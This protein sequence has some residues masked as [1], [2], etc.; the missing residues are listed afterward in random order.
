MAK[1]TSQ[2]QRQKR[3]A[4]NSS[5]Y[6]QGLALV[7]R[8]LACIMWGLVGLVLLGAGLSWTEGGEVKVA[9][10]LGG[11]GVIAAIGGVFWYFNLRAAAGRAPAMTDVG[12]VMCAIFGI[13]MISGGLSI[14]FGTPGAGLNIDRNGVV[15]V[16]FGVVAMGLGAAIR[17]LHRVPPGKKRIAVEHCRYAG[18][19]HITVADG[20]SRAEQDRLRQSW[21]ESRYAERPDWVSGRIET[22]R[23]RI[24]KAAYWI[25]GVLWAMAA[26]FWLGN[27]AG[28]TSSFVAAIFTLMAGAAS[29]PGVG[30]YLH[31]RKFAP[32]FLMPDPLPI[33][34]G[35]PVDLTVETGLRRSDM[36]EALCIL[37]LSCIY[38]YT[39]TVSRP[40]RSGEGRRTETTQKTLWSQEDIVAA[41][42]RDGS[43][44]LYLKARFNVPRSQ[45]PSSLRRSGDDIRWQLDVATD[46]PGS[47]Y[48]V[49]FKVPVLDAGVELDF[50]AMAHRRGLVR[51]SSR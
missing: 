10:T 3:R 18:A 17:Y 45:P 16:G 44:V 35:K 30:I 51:S 37:T 25:A 9:N 38:T 14:A 13:V 49:R 7:L 5:P 19:V 29:L 28:I 43:D 23:A 33:R 21:R 8:V 42:P 4:Q 15:L 48:A 46:V 36:G 11:T 41:K 12:A 2:R 6:D 26:G 31:R 27:S 39:E 40:V 34:L 47:P 24:G 22:D 32:S 20:I 50:D 1:K